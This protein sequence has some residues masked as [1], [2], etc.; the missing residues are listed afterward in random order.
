ML[1]IRAFEPQRDA[2]QLYTLWRQT[3]GHLWPLAYET[4]EAVTMTNPAYRPGDHLVACVGEEIVGFV[5][6]QA[7]QHLSS[8][9]GNLLVLLVAPAYQR[10]GI[11]RMLHDHA[12][13]LLKQ[14]GAGEV[15]LGGGFHYFWQGVPTSLP[16]AWPF[17]QACG[18]KEVERSFDLVREMSGYATPPG[19]YERLGPTITIEQATSADA[20]AILAFEEQHFPQWL[21]H[22]QRVLHHHGYADVVVAKETY[23]GIVGTSFVLDPHAAWWQHDIR[24]LDLLGGNTGGVGPL[25]VAE[26]M[27]GQGI[28]LALAA[29]VTELLW[30]RRL[31]KSYV[32]W[33]WLVDWYGK[34]GYQVWQEYLMSWRKQ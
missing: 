3:L 25:G 5:A 18:W 23:Q 8:L 29:R 22:Y 19:V 20:D 4:F 28:G 24:W 34:L 10:Q 9:R 30:E 21:R 17:F 6:T 15:Q 14:R 2:Q 1:M 16:G 13:T 12:F 26:S 7:Q 32:G 11:G 31:A 27:R 33:T